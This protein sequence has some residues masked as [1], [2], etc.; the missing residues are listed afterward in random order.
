MQDLR[1]K[2]CN[3]LLGKYLDCKQLE[4][5]C[6]RC[7]LSNYVRENLSCTSREKSCPV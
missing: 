6:P 4:I 3:K 5:K 2:K 1:C 7:G